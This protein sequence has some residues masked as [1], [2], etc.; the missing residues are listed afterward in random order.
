MFI[1]FFYGVTFITVAHLNFLIKR[2]HQNWL[3]ISLN[4]RDVKGI[5]T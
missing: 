3:R 4:A 5:C 1:F 2:S